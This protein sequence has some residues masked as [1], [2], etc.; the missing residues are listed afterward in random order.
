MQPLWCLTAPPSP[1]GAVGPWVLSHGAMSLQKS[2]ECFILSPP[3]MGWQGNTIRKGE[4]RP[5][6][7]VTR[8]PV[9]KSGAARIG[10]ASVA[11]QSAEYLS[12]HMTLKVTP[13]TL[14]LYSSP[15]RAIPQPSARRAIK[16]KNPWARKG[17]SILRTFPFSTL[18][19]NPPPSGG[20]NLRPVGPSTFTPKGRVIK[21]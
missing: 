19:H 18:L 13:V 17:P 20:H 14:A 15:D 1:R 21:L 3:R 2:I 11:S 16:L 5:E 10:G 6:N 8:F 12:C 4:K 7:R 9:E